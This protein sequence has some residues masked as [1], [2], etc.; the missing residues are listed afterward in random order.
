MKVGKEKGIKKTK[1]DHFP[2]HD[3]KCQELKG[4][5]NKVHQDPEE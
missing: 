4:I 3:G 2:S 5:I 1:R